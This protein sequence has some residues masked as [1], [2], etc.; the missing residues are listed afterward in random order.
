MQPMPSV[1]SSQASTSQPST[2]TPSRKT[3]ISINAR[4]IENYRAQSVAKPQP[5]NSTPTLP[6]TNGISRTDAIASRNLLVAPNE[7]KEVKTSAMEAPSRMRDLLTNRRDKTLLDDAVIGCPNGH[8]DS[9]QGIRQDLKYTNKCRY[10]GCKGIIDPAYLFPNLSVRMIVADVKAGRYVKSSEQKALI[11]QQKETIETQDETIQVQKELLDQLNQCLLQRME[12][13]GRCLDAMAVQESLNSEQRQTIALLR[14][15]LTK[16][17]EDLKGCVSE[18]AGLHEMIDNL[19][20]S[21]KKYKTKLFINEEE[22]KQ[23]VANLEGAIAKQINQNEVLL[24]LQKKKYEALSARTQQLQLKFSRLRTLSDAKLAESQASVAS[25][26]RERRDQSAIIAVANSTIVELQGSIRKKD[27]EVASKKIIIAHLKKDNNSKAA[28]IAAHTQAI[29]QLQNMSDTQAAA[30]VEN[31]QTIRQLQSTNS[32]QTATIAAH[33]QAIAQLQNTNDMQAAAIVENQQTIRQLQST[34]SMQAAAIDEKQQTIVQLHLTNSTHAGTIASHAQTISRLQSTNGK[35]AANITED[36]AMIAQLQ[37]VNKAQAGA[38]ARSKQ[39]FRQLQNTTSAQADALV[40]KEQTIE[41]LQ[42]IVRSKNEKITAK[43]DAI[44]TLRSTH[45]AQTATIAAHTQT[46][47]QLQNTNGTQA[48]AIVGNQ[49]NIAQLENDYMQLCEEKYQQALEMLKKKKTRAKAHTMVSSI[50]NDP[51]VTGG[52]K[53]QANITMGDIYYFKLSDRTRNYSRAKH[54]YAQVARSR[55]KSPRENYLIGMCLMKI[56]DSKGTVDYATA[57]QYFME[58][59]KQGHKEA[60]YQ[61]GICS[62]SL[63]NHERAITEFKSSVKNKVM[64][65]HAASAI[66]ECYTALKDHD[67]AAKWVGLATRFGIIGLFTG[68]LGKKT[69]KPAQ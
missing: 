39:A 51:R 3:G 37:T 15:S 17:L 57:H 45:S 40:E 59:K 33:T 38:L 7:P 16:A 61:A 22:H 20:A 41:V 64:S 42:R 11:Q 21:Q 62:S 10:E 13:I 29:A 9:L 69:I 56:K 48:A 25:L 60:S 12:E 44:A 65:V 46:I 34:N 8:T 32:M 43:K 23:E 24:Q 5:K 63:K 52:L 67:N 6:D 4:L 55:L 28:T 1:S 50:A 66:R 68:K 49:Q 30:I 14:L 2:S 36:E 26:R 53:I 54:Y 27:G 47:A 19:Q 18:I 58:A 31:Q 35:Q